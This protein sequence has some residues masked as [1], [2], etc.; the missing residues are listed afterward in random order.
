MD[1]PQSDPN[2]TYRALEEAHPF[3]SFE[4]FWQP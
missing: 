2:V 3:T 1:K 4:K